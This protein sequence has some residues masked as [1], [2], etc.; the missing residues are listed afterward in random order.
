MR[1]VCFRISVEYRCAWRNWWSKVFGSETVNV[2]EC[3]QEV[4]ESVSVSG[5]GCSG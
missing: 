2:M 1:F 5:Y 4:D 3:V